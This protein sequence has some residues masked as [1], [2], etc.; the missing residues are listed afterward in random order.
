MTLFN[1]FNTSDN[2]LDAITKEITLFPKSG[3]KT[4][5]GRLRSYNIR[6]PRIKV[7]ESLQRVDPS[8]FRS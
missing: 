8:G 4:V 5:S 6:L 7:R 1:S 3:E 2:Q